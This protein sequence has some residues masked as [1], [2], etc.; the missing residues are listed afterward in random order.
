MQ[1]ERDDNGPNGLSRI[2]HRV[3]TYVLDSGGDPV[4]EPDFTAWS[5]WY[6]HSQDRF[7]KCDKLTGDIRISTVF[8]GLDLTMDRGSAVLWETRVLG[9]PHDGYY[10]TYTSKTSALAG[11][12]FVLGFAAA[13]AR[14]KK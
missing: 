12:D 14:E 11:H 2:H 1:S 10:Q 6:E 3:R 5:I 9:G 13:A 4:P 7:L 8:L